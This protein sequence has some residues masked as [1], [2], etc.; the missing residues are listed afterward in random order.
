M[1]RFAALLSATIFAVALPVAASGQTATSPA[2]PTSAPAADQA[3]QPAQSFLDTVVC[4][5]EGPLLGSRLGA[6]KVCL[7]NRQWEQR[8]HDAQAAVENVK[9]TQAT[10][11]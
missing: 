9:H 7:T 3:G 1:N 11:H 6:H 5:E 8:A 4:K 10:P 2:A